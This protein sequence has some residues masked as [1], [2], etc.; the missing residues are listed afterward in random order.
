MLERGENSR[1]DLLSECVI[2][3]GWLRRWEE[4]ND[5]FDERRVNEIEFEIL[6]QYLKDMYLSPLE[7]GEVYYKLKDRLDM[8]EKIRQKIKAIST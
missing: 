5:V 3:R 7:Y 6:K 4:I 2:M 8:G 1:V